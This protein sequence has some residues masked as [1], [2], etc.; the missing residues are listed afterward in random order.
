[1]Q[2]FLHINKTS[3]NLS[4]KY[5]QENKKR[6]QNKKLVKGIKIVLNKK[7]KKKPQYGRERCKNLSEDK[8]TK[9]C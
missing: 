9:A 1:M 5:F 4:A 6:L 2:F 8:K 7:N 3:K